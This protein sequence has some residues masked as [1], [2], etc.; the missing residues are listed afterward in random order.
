MSHT[1]GKTITDRCL[2]TKMFSP[3]QEKSL[4]W[5]RR[6]KNII[7]ILLEFLLPRDLVLKSLDL[8]GGWKLFYSG[9]DPSMFAQAGVGILTNH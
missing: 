3:S 4:N 5:Q 6:Q 9:A 8:D 7:S 1:F 2:A